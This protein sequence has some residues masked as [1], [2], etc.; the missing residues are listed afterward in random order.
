MSRYHAAHQ[1]LNGPGDARPSAMQIVEDE[2]LVGKLSDK[3]MLVTGTSSGIGI[4]TARALAATGAHIFC[5]VRNVAKGEAALKDILKPGQ[6]EIIQMDQNSLESVRHGAKE[7]LE[8]SN[9]KCN[10]LVCNAGIMAC[11]QA[12]SADGFESQFAVC[13][14]A[15]FQLFVLLKDALSNSSSKDFDSRGR[16]SVEF[17]QK[18]WNADF[19]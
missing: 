17:G 7:Y 10:V 16:F 6:V 14:L 5:T 19:S 9:G 12:K 13:H 8:R 2:G 11:P 4:E 1:S 18:L 15:H 3:T